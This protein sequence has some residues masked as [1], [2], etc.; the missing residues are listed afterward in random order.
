MQLN[1]RNQ[2]IEIVARQRNIFMVLCML[3]LVCLLI[4]SLKL[5]S[6]HERTI[7]IPG[8]NQ[9]AWAS[10]KGVSSSYLEETT[11][12]YLPLL[13]DLDS[14]SIDWKRDRIMTYVSNSN[15]L[16]LKLLTEYFARVKEQYNQF[17]LSTHF[18]LKKLV[19]NPEQ[20]KVKAYGQLVSRFGDRGFE[21]EIAAYSLSY[22]WVAGRLLIKEFTK[23]SKE[24]SQDA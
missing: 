16:N 22:E 6:T 15:E 12:M 3:S 20:L 21:S 11:V 13:L 7:L 9:E 8:L 1:I 4:V 18:A 24:E 23:L 10:D 5:L 17:S 14:T 19:T 2:N